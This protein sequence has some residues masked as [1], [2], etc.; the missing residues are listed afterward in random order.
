MISSARIAQMAN[1]AEL[2]FKQL[3]YLNVGDPGWI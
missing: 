2:L 1:L 3:I